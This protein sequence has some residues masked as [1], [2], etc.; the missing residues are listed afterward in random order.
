MIA[1]I[2]RGAE[3][4]YEI[5]F[6][7]TSYIE[8]LRA[9]DQ[10]ERLPESI[11]RLPLEGAADVRMR[12]AKLVAELD[13]ASRQLDDKA[14]MLIKDALY[15][16]GMALARLQALDVPH[17]LMDILLVD[18]NPA[19]ARVTQEALTSAGIPHQLHVVSDDRDAIS[20]LNRSRQFADAPQPDVVLVDLHVTPECGRKVLS[21]IRASDRL[22]HIP[23]VLLTGAGS[24]RIGGRNSEA[25]VGDAVTHTSGID[26][27]VRQIKSIQSRRPRR[28]AYPGIPARD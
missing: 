2:L 14:C 10:Y 28:E 27:F 8:A 20:Y 18:G 24:A 15:V 11:T 22:R 26:A 12:C 21:E 1:E 19:D 23:V 16:L 17:K 7:L 5:Y 4:E 25:G 3:N 13:V 9:D 6:L